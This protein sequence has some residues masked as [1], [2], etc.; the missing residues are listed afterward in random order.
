[1]HSTAPLCL[2]SLTAAITHLSGELAYGKLKDNQP[3]HPKIK[4]G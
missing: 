3:L 2:S 1:M 4:V